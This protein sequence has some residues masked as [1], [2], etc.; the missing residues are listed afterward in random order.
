MWISPAQRKLNGILSV[1]RVAFGAMP[2]STPRYSAA[3][4]AKNSASF[5]DR[6]GRDAKPLRARSRNATRRRPL[7][8]DDWRRSA[9]PALCRSAACPGSAPA[10]H[11][12]CRV[13]R[14][15]DPF[16]CAVGNQAIDLFVE[17]GRVERQRTSAHRVRGIE[18]L[19]G[20]RVVA[21]IIGR[22]AE[23]S[24]G[25][26]AGPLPGRAWPAQLPSVAASRHPRC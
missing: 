18:M 9:P 20:Q 24:A 19:H 2:R 26:R 11:R 3:A 22:F 5:V 7:P 23:A 4:W 8:R 13:R 17:R 10:S 15:C 6:G 1:T 14:S 12:R 16:A 25:A 21:E